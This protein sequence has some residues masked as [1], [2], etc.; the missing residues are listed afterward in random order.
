M[1][2]VNSELSGEEIEK[3]FE[4]VC[5]LI[6]SGETLG[7]MSSFCQDGDQQQANVCIKAGL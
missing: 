4:L 7:A 5:F 1:I 2:I 3:S 6:L